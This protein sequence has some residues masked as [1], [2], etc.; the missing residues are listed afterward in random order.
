MAKQ[1]NNRRRISVP[2]SGLDTSTPDLTVADGKCEELH[3]LRWETGGWHNIDPLKIKHSLR[4]PGE[5]KEWLPKISII[6]HHP[7]AGDDTYIASVP[8]DDSAIYLLTVII[9]NET[10]YWDYGDV[11]TERLSSD[12][13]ITH[14]GNILIVMDNTNQQ[15]VHYYLNS[16]TYEEFQ[17]PQP[18]VVRQSTILGLEG[19]GGVDSSNKPITCTGIAKYKTNEVKNG[20]PFTT[21]QQGYSISLKSVRNISG[22]KYAFSQ[23]SRWPTALSYHHRPSSSPHLNRSPQGSNIANTLIFP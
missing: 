1:E 3:N 22:V 12:I 6:Y 8:Y 10:I 20:V 16:G 13:R 15:V 14:F 23:H 11:F 21:S 9:D 4:V 19:Y 17:I 5:D 7:A 2:V 18:P